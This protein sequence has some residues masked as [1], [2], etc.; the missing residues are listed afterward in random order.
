MTSTVA[1]LDV[2]FES[3]CPG[4]LAISPGPASLHTTALAIVYMRLAAK[5]RHPLAEV[6]ILS[7]A[8]QD[9]DTGPRSVSLVTGQ[10]VA[11]RPRSTLRQRSRPPPGQ[12]IS[13]LGLL[14]PCLDHTE[15]LHKLE[16]MPEAGQKCQQI[17]ARL[18]PLRLW[19]PP[20]TRH[21]PASQPG[22]YSAACRAYF[23]KA[24]TSKM[25]FLM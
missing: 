22:P 15:L 6:R 13:R 23:V 20:T 2:L 18:E 11:G 12:L 3:Y 9:I 4:R 7:K 8:L 1:V 21:A 5:S 17:T 24:E 10:G 25:G 19:R 16:R 14:A